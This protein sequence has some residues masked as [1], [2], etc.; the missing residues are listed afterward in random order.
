[1]TAIWRPTNA[2]LLVVVGGSDEYDTVARMALDRGAR[3]GT[4]LPIWWQDTADRLPSE[5]LGRAQAV[6]VED[7]RFGDRAVAERALASY[8]SNGGRVLLD[9]HGGSAA[10]SALWPIET[11]TDDAIA[12]WHLHAAAADVRV[13]QFSPARYGDGPWG[14][15]VATA[16]R[17]DARALLGRAG[18]ALIAERSMGSGA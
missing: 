14:A 8:A 4:L 13:D 11:A 7:G 5:L 15:P 18:R 6:V 9:A 12:E 10:L 3:P 2:P 1:P 17:A 16:V